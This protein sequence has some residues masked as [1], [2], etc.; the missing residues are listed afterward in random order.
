MKKN[1]QFSIVY[2]D[3]HILVLNKASGLLV[4]ADRWDPDATRLDILA[5]KEFCAE[6]ERLYAV[7]RIDKD[8]SGLIMYAKTAAAHRTLSIDFQERSVKK[9]YHVLVHGRP[10]WQETEIAIPL[11]AD[12]DQKHRTV[13]DLK[14]GKPS[15][16]KFTV[17][18][19]CGA[20]TW[21]EANL[22]TGRTHQIR[23]HLELSGLS[24]VCDPLYGDG[25][26]LFLSQFKR[27]WRGDPFTERP[28]LDRL[29]LHAW[30]MELTHPET[31]NLEVFTAPYP[32]DF[33]ATRNQLAKR[34]GT[35]PL[36]PPEKE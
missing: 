5:A 33:D 11:R 30:K 17:L 14:H 19:E 6:G 7:H 3:E 29:A 28:L 31:G 13:R 34:F 22:I 24:I 15:V 36:N 27:S 8:T 10:L 32:R 21:L 25:K 18:G 9:L 12:G 4:A 26:P 2:Q 35:D 20:F 1:E 16:T 23:A